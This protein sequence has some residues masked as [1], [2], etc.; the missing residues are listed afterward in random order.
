MHPF[1]S[2]FLS[3]ITADFTSGTKIISEPGVYKLCEDIIF[4]P[5][6]P[7]GD[8]PDEDAYDPVFPS[9]Y[10]ENA[11]GLGFFAA[12][13]VDAPNVELRLNGHSIEQSKGHALF[14][15]Y[16]AVI[17]LASSPFIKSAGP[18][19]FVGEGEECISASNLKILGPGIIG[20]SSHHGIHG[21][22]N[23]NVE[24]RDVTFIDFEV[25]A[26][27]LN[28]IDG[29]VIQGCSVKHNRHDVPVSAMFSAARFIRPYGKA[30]KER[31]YSMNLRGEE[32][33][34]GQAYDD[35]INA[36]NNIYFDVIAYGE[37]D[38]DQHRMEY[39]LFRNHFK[40]IDGPWYVSQKQASSYLQRP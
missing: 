14:Q 18:A 31:G 5:N 4:D 10:S 34:A 13:A 1:R 11:F 33:T 8:V 21:N 19:Q 22:D 36:I 39:D 38:P 6:A 17:E 24:I 3:L 9:D 28:N 27:S 12:I 20:R 15:R 32:T 37:I 26:V 7:V 29:L 30:L 16:F 2:Y 35:L 40:T 25:A 23:N